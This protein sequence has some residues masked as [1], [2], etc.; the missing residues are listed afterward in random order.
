MRQNHFQVCYFKEGSF[1]CCRD[2]IQMVGGVQASFTKD[3]LEERINF[4]LST[5]LQKDKEDQREAEDEEDKRVGLWVIKQS[6]EK[7]DEG[8]FIVFTKK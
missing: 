3:S 4:T 6:S 8:L 5:F 2:K 7:F 1:S